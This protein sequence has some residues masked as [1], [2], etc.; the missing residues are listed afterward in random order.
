MIT[1]PVSSAS[2]ERSFSCLKRIHSYLRNTQGQK[3][4]SE[5]SLISIEKE[6]LCSL[7][8]SGTFYKDILDIY[9]EKDRRV[10]LVYR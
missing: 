5:L 10:D 9:L 2:A 3:R 4:L 7:Q 1:I 6:L 8:R